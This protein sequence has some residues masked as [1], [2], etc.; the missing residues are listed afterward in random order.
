MLN[1]TYITAAVTLLAQTIISPVAL[2][3]ENTEPLQL[4]SLHVIGNQENEYSVQNT[5]SATRTDTPIKQIPQSIHVVPRQLIDDQQNITV[6]EALAN[7][8]SVRTNAEFSSPATESTLVRGFAAEQLIDG[9]SQFY[10][11]GDRESL[12]NVDSIE[13]LKGSNAVLFSGGSGSPVGGVINI[14]SKSPQAEQFGELGV[15]VGSNHFMQPFFDINQPITENVLFRITGEYTNAESHVDV[16]EQDR[17]N[18]NPSLVLTNNDDTKLTLQGK[19]SK[20]SQQEYQGLPVTGTVIGNFKIKPDLFIGNENIPDSK[21]EFN[22]IWASLEHQI[23][24]QWSFNLKARYAKSEFDEKVQSIVGADGFAANAPFIGP[25]TWGLANNV[26]F[27]KQ[28]EHSILGNT[29]FKFDVGETKNTLLFGADYS[30][31]KDEGFLTSDAFITINTVDLAN[32]TFNSPYVEPTKSAFTTVNDSI[33]KNTTYGVYVQ[34]QSTIAERIHLLAGLRQGTVKVHYNELTTGN[35]VETD[36]SELLPRLGA[37]YDFNPLVSIF[38][39]YGEGLRA[40]PF[41]TFAP[42]TAPKA[43][44]SK[45]TEAG[46][47]FDFNSKLTGQFAFYN[48]ERTNIAVGFPSTP[49]GEQQSKGFDIDM[50]WHPTIA[51][52]LLANYAH[53]DTIYTN[54]VSATVTSGNKVAGVPDDSALIWANYQFQRRALKGIRAGIGV[55]WQSDVFVDNANT[56]TVDGFHT[57]DAAINYE[58]DRYKLGLTIKNLTNKDYVQFYNYFGGRVSPDNGVTAFLSAAIKY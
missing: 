37:V 24:E 57:V 11:P 7:V 30:E 19:L 29:T 43:P 53:T 35:V 17:H 44:R 5:S 3:N 46:L 54:D 27:Q 45:N 14:N 56:F 47:K 18:I 10:N 49:T 32:P 39:S 48:I 25:S 34:L 41:A 36:E 28:R 26:L 31:L 22:G 52:T 58:T 9:F 1:K 23:N 6:S 21:S 51:W 38:A 33:L 2:S 15:K 40:A 50:T 4:E 55:K 12:I 20:W 16:I 42:G 13:V 8:S